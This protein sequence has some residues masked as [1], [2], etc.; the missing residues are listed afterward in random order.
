MTLYL[1]DDL[2]AVVTPVGFPECVDQHVTVEVK[3]TIGCPVTDM[4]DI[5]RGIAE[6]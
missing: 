6:I 1:P 3:M 4:A 2:G 5:D